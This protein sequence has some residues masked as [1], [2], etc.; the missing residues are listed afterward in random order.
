M[1]VSSITAL[2]PDLQ[3]L[4]QS[5]TVLPDILYSP[6]PS[7]ALAQTSLQHRLESPNDS[8][9]V[10]WSTHRLAT[11]LPRSYQLWR[12]SSKEPCDPSTIGDGELLVNTTAP[13]PPVEKITRPT[14]ATTATSA[15]ISNP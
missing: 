10:S 12:P 14:I 1:N 15:A 7:H 3:F 2:Q 8:L 11:F 4:K 13:D 6:T 5:S 9:V